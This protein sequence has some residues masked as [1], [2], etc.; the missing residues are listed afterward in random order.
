VQAA[1]NGL[2]QFP[3]DPELTGLRQTAIDRRRKADEA[4][5]LLE[6]GQ[7]LFSSDPATALEKV[8]AAY[9]LDRGSL[10]IRAVLVDFLTR[11]A[12]AL[13]ETEPVRA[14]EF[15]RK[16]LELDPSNGP[17]RNLSTFL[18]DRRRQADTGAHL[19][20]AR[21]LREQGD[22]QA[23]RSEV[24]S[25]L[26]AYPGDPR[27]TQ[28][29]AGLDQEMREEPATAVMGTPTAVVEAPP[30][31]GPAPVAIGAK[32]WL[33]G[34]AIGVA[35]A[36]LFALPFLWNRSGTEQTPAQPGALTLRVET[37]PEARIFVDGQPQ[38]EGVVKLAPRDQPYSIEARLPG[39]RSPAPVMVTVSKT[40]TALEPVRL[41]LQP[42]PTSLLIV[43]AMNAKLNGQPV[44]LT[45]PVQ[46]APGV[47]K[48]ELV[49]ATGSALSFDVEA[50]AGRLPLISNL[51]A[52][53]LSLA[54][55]VTTFASEGHVYV[56]PAPQN[57]T[58]DGGAPQ[59]VNEEGLALHSLAPAD[60]E[61]KFGNASPQII[62]V[63][64]SPAVH[65]QAAAGEIE[66]GMLS[67][68]IPQEGATVTLQPGNRQLPVRNG[69]AVAYGLKP[70][71]YTLSISAPGHRAV[72]EQ[73]TIE[74]G[75][76]LSR[77]FELTA[78]ERPTALS[79]AGL[80]PGT[81]V[82]VND[83]L[84]GT[85]GGDGAVALPNIGPGRKQILL[86]HPRYESRRITQDLSIGD[87]VQ[88][89]GEA[90]RMVAFGS[91]RINVTPP[92]SRIFYRPKGSG[93]YQEAKENPFFVRQGEYDVQIRADKFQDGNLPI[94]VFPGKPSESAVA[95]TA[96]APVV[97]PAETVKLFL[98]ADF[99]GR[100]TLDKTGWYMAKDVK[101]KPVIE[102]GILQFSAQ[103]KG[104]VFKKDRARWSL[105]SAS[106]GQCTEFELTAKQF[107]SGP[108][109]AENKRM[110]DHGLG[111]AANSYRVVVQFLAGGITQTI[112]ASPGGSPK[113]LDSRA[114]LAGG[115][116]FRFV[117]LGV[118]SFDFTGQVK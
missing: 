73:I 105:R 21:S 37:E 23:A 116:E 35:A 55:V 104:G 106:T 89:S 75:K 74:K 62:A 39:Y 103:L 70:G 67:L 59:T 50:R 96:V 97:A 14:A 19:A 25:A 46:L 8:A 54:S 111:D 10:V 57:V 115:A 95:L 36:A 82:I 69:R 53:A 56:K 61:L 107:G 71:A 114:A 6:E 3:D 65:V 31:P 2:A 48:L 24:T 66:T 17:A 9:Q 90:S 100:S 87:N 60:H 4:S 77:K 86:R 34:T 29:L 43:S 11:R 1:A 16:A 44:S 88:L 47:H 83:Q 20:R 26:A 18:A 15:V 32:H 113:Q 41:T 40:A 93:T 63:N 51:T 79:F 64:D 102:S 101:L 85:A 81:E 112:A 84:V 30:L 80:P 110:T 109:G 78:V 38:P 91:I 94:T 5:L 13:Q 33:V 52:R 45:E 76:Q 68:A 99:Q 98:P 117:D 92:G 22:L 42:H 58:I 118:R 27:L 7:R 12:A 49:S 72:T 108:C 28:F